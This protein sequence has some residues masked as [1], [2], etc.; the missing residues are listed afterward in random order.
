MSYCSEENKRSRKAAIAVTIG[1]ILGVVAVFA[2]L[3]GIVFGIGYAVDT[4]ASEMVQNVLA[5]I[6]IGFLSLIVV[7]G[8]VVAF[9]DLYKE[10]L[11]KR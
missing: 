2:A 3:F 10:N 6:L 5:V 7:G 11:C 9:H 1:Q 4:Y 8:A